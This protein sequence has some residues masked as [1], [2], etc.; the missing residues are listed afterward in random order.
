MDIGNV[1]NGKCENLNTKSAASL[2]TFS[3]TGH[4]SY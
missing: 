4:V 3:G 1:K 2:S